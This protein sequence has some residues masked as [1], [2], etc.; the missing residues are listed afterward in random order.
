MMGRARQQACAIVSILLHSTF[1]LPKQRTRRLDRR[2][3][4]KSLRWS[5]RKRRS[6]FSKVRPSLVLRGYATACLFSVLNKGNR[7]LKRGM[8]YSTIQERRPYCIT[9][10]W[11]CICLYCSTRPPYHSSTGRRD[12]TEAVSDSCRNGRVGTTHG[13]KPTRNGGTHNTPWLQGC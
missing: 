10:E 11:T 8:I 5:Q 3:D 4:V 12:G 7:N 13:C 2:R 1:T 6:R 9:H